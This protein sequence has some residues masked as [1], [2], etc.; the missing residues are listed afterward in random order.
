[1]VPYTTYLDNQNVAGTI[2][3]LFSPTAADTA[4]TASHL[5]PSSPGP[6]L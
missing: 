1:M 2:D 6:A 4:I 5:A 3:M